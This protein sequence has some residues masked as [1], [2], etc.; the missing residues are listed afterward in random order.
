MPKR[1]PA[2]LEN[3][4][5]QDYW[6]E[7]AGEPGFS[8]DFKGLEKLPLI[9]LYFPAASDRGCHLCALG[10]GLS[11]QEVASGNYFRFRHQG[12]RPE[13]ANPMAAMRP[14]LSRSA[15]LCRFILMDV[16]SGSSAEGGLGSQ[17][18]LLKSSPNE[19]PS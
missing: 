8:H 7:L 11:Q 4:G 1:D 2:R 19:Q 12:C 9:S 5:N 3:Q 16:H 10:L 6:G 13:T 15:S 17:P 18:Q 14:H